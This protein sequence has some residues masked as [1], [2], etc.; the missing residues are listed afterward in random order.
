[1]NNDKAIFYEVPKEIILSFGEFESQEICYLL[2]G[3]CLTPWDVQDNRIHPESGVAPALSGCDGG[4]GRHPGGKVFQAIE[5]FPC[6]A[7]HQNQL[8][9]LRLGD[10]ANTLSTNSNT[11]GRN[12]PIVLA[13]AGFNGWR[14]VTGSLEY[15][16]NRA[17]CIQA[18]MP[19]NVM[20]A[21]KIFAEDFLCIAYV[22]RRFTPIETERLMGF[23]DGWTEFGK[24]EWGEQEKI[25]DGKRYQLMGNS[26]CIPI[27]EFILNGIVEAEKRTPTTKT[28]KGRG[29]YE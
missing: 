4:G 3:E 21:M 22:I 19:S 15:A 28:Q 18:T 16:E 10:V 6:A 13:S 8:G 2:E 24:N 23:P 20:E 12:A 9:E 26:V 7:I 1:L 11:S 5:I 25:S 27:V 14:S 17:P 29:R